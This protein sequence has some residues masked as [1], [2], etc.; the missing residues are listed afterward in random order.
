[1]IIN[2]ATKTGKAFIVVAVLLFVVAGSASKDAVEW[3]ARADSLES[4][5]RTAPRE[6][7]AAPDPNYVSSSDKVA[8]CS[9]SSALIVHRKFLAWREA[10]DANIRGYIKRNKPDTAWL[11]YNR[12]SD[13]L[14]KIGDAITWWEKQCGRASH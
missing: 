1:M 2:T 9:D 3:K 11:S 8:L 14:A 10:S 4:L 12:R 7:V 6:R 5:V 13:S